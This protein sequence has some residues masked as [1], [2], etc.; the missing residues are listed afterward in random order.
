ME[1][2]KRMGCREG[3]GRR[4]GFIKEIE[5]VE[6]PGWK[7]RR[8]R[9]KCFEGADADVGTSGSRGSAGNAGGV[10]GRKTAEGLNS[11]CGVKAL[12]DTAVTASAERMSRGLELL[13]SWESCWSQESSGKGGEPAM[14][15]GKKALQDGGNR[16]S[17]N[18]PLH[19]GGEVR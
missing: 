4:A 10:T 7:S 6:R 3:F 1:K 17:T 19:R 18:T 5:V 15:K 14:E 16:R 2:R 9:Q 11:R 8:L 12:Q 13:V